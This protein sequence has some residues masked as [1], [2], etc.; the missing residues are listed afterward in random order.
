MRAHAGQAARAVFKLLRRALSLMLALVVVALCGLGALG[1]LL[2]LGP[3]E[4]PWLVRRLEAVLNVDGGPRW[5]IG[6]VAMAWEGFG[7]GL[8]RPIDLRIDDVVVLAANGAMIGRVPRA[9]VS[10]AVTQLL[11]GRLVPRAIELEGAR[12]RAERMADG[13]MRV[14][15]VEAVTGGGDSPSGVEVADVMAALARPAGV[16]DDGPLAA[17]LLDHLRRVQIRDAGLE[18]VDDRLAT[19][20]TA[21]QLAIDLT[22]EPGGGAHGTVTL[23][24]ALGAQQAHLSG[25]VELGSGADFLRVHAATSA[26][27]PARLAADM[28]LFAAG[29]ALDAP[30][31]VEGSLL[32]DHA[33]TWREADAV[34]RLGAGQVAVA[35]GM[36]PL[37][38]AEARL[39]A[40]PGTVSLSGIRLDLQPAGRPI[41]RVT[42]SG[43]VS[44]APD[45][46]II[47]LTAGTEFADFADLPALWPD[48]VGGRGAK[49]WL[50]ENMP[51]GI[52][53]DL[54]AAMTMRAAPDLSGLHVTSLTGGGDG[55]DLVV[56]WLRPVPPVEQGV[57]HLD[58]VSPD[59]IDIVM[60]SG[61]QG[62]VQVTGGL[63]R[64]FGMSV[65]DQV[66]DITVEAAGPLADA[67]NVLRNPRM[68]LLDRRPIELRDPAG[69]MKGRLDISKMPLE[70]WLTIDDVQLRTAVHM[71]GVHLGGVAAGRDLDDGQLDLQA[72][73]DALRV[74][75]TGNVAGI[76]AKLLVDMDFRP[77]PAAQ[78]IQNV[79]VSGTPDAAQV[80]GLGIDLGG[81]VSG[82]APVSATWRTRRDGKGDVTVKADLTPAVLSLSRL[83]FTKPAG[84]PAQAEMSVALERDKVAAIDRLSVKGEGVDAEARIAFADGRP[85]SARVPVLVLGRDTNVHADIRFP[86]PSG[87]G[88]TITLGGISLNASAEFTRRPP[89]TPKP[90]EVRGP[91]YVLD[92]RLDRVVLGEGRSISQLNLHA[93]NDG[94]INRQMRL[95]GRPGGL[96]P[97]DIAI[98]TA[99][100]GRNLTGAAGDAGG[101]LKALD[102]VDDMQGGTMTLSGR[103]DD[104]AAGHPLEGTAEILDFR[105]S[106]AP[107]LAKL[108]QAMTLYGLVELVRGPGLGFNRLDA[109]FRL[110]EDVLELR[111]ARAFNTSLGMTA[112]GRADIAAQRCDMS[113]TI[114][115]AYF[116]NSMLG[117]IP[118]L[119][120]LFSPERGGGLFAAT[121]SLRGDCNDP[122]VA[123]NPLAAL[124]P[125]FLRGIFGIFDTPDETQT[126]PPAGQS[127]R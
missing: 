123:V 28:P 88:W 54:H 98:T 30:V 91:A 110:T 33:M 14:D 17:L 56:H 87:G 117:G 47:E 40:S 84:K 121:Y 6:R 103:F 37:A 97:F 100:G 20:W 52:V 64:I 24:L 101:L 75:G 48:G 23:T 36:L 71:S 25:A 3:L 126:K 104:M 109:P 8:D 46:I 94:L 43:G 116:F 83:G 58:I 41:T 112:K 105:M 35:R 119:G 120:K 27:N 2:S 62:G 106:K 65:R 78:I 12:L 9:H 5:S 44:F 125:G 34:L 113:G 49:P 59:I 15:L 63:M 111:D 124:T 67:M 29:Q 85:V 10:L 26:I 18:V 51:A 13:Q 102:I 89:G 127:G 122:A 118:F 73:N 21:S 42:G 95:S 108:L 115:P 45:G 99:Q 7:S 72:S 61:R 86:P 69:Q 22:R 4:V 93:E 81:T 38:G 82:A 31:T 70:S 32:V 39:H 76:P 79:T 11:R 57:A 53:T 55:H 114:V 19:R 96:A 90:P 92:A 107:A 50:V 80:A 16:M 66:T 1:W 60:L 74:T 77:G 68:H